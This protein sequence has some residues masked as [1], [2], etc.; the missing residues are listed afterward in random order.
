MKRLVT[1]LLGA[2][3][4]AAC[5]DQSPVAPLPVVPS[6]SASV[7][8]SSVGTVFVLNGNDAGNGSLR[9]AIS[10]ASA[11]PNITTIAFKSTR[12]IA[13]RSTLTFT[14]SQDLAIDG[15]RSIIDAAAAGGTALAFVGGGDLRV[16]NLSVRNAPGEGIDVEVPATATG[17]V[18][19]TLSNVAIED[20]DGHGVLINDQVDPSTTDGVQ[21]D[22]RGSDASLDVTV[23]G[24]RFRR[25]GFSVSDRDG[26]RVNEGGVGSLT[27][28]LT[29]SSAEDNAADGVEIDERGV[30][31]VTANVVGTRF[32][33]NGSFD[34][35]D[36][37]DGFDI[38]EYNEGSVLA[39]VSFSSASHN[40]E[41]GFDFN[42]NNAGD[43]RVEM[44]FVEASDNR[45]EGI[46][47]EEDDDD[48]SF[49]S[50]GGGDLVTTLVA[51][52]ANRNG[53]DG[54]DAGV[55]IREKLLG[56]LDATVKGVDASENLIGGISVREDGTGNL[57]AAISHAKAL[58]NAGHG[59]DF[60]ENAAGD[61]TATVSNSTSAHNGLFGVRADQ[62][63]ASGLGVG[64]LTLSAVT[65]SNNVGGT[66]TGSNVSLLMQ[67]PLPTA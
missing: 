61:L 9:A 18:K 63:L 23:L 16:S 34:P 46:D 29:L 35:D 21:P 62:Q 45:E 22:A 60:D 56:N 26:L 28:N 31:D 64:S 7:A 2:G 67:R 33:R 5:A 42:E 65:I 43:F 49:G 32:L 48:A 52:K 10:A 24:S 66:T 55:K 36:L 41:E 20:N 50:I 8:Q 17:T 53:I 57:L 27:L 44:S 40:F 15:A 6:P 1:A 51:I 37:D 3:A 38:D 25:N 59:I 19:V 12:T 13:L 58:T 14:G 39:K 54:G 30:G 11:N 47:F 4:L